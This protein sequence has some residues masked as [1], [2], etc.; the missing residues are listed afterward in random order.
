[1]SRDILHPLYDYPLGS[2]SMPANFLNMVFSLGLE[3]ARRSADLRAGCRFRSPDAI[4]RVTA[5]AP[6]ATAF[7]IHDRKLKM[8]RGHRNK[9]LFHASVWG[10]I[11]IRVV[12][13]GT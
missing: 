5:L 4:Q 11:F 3:V 6:E 13:A 9:G 10:L 12:V 7:P 1:L 8:S 2:L